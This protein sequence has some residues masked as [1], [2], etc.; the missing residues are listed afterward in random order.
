MKNKP[1]LPLK[2]RVLRWIARLWSL[3]IFIFAI[4]M[5]FSP[6]PYATGE[7]ISTE[8]YVLLGLWGFSAVGLLIAWLWERLGA[9]V[10]IIAL[11]LRELLYFILNGSWILNFL[12]IWL[13]F[14]PPAIMY[15]LAWRMEQKIPLHMR[16]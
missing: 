10:A 11:V 3:A 7:P 5:A 6:D 14:L 9:W 13:V 15:L 1:P 2:I 8:T 12:L 16:R 4:L